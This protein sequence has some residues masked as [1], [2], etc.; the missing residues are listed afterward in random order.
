[1]LACLPHNSTQDMN[2]WR[3]SRE[4]R[5]EGPYAHG[6]R[7]LEVLQDRRRSNHLVRRGTA[8]GKEAN[9]WVTDLEDSIH[10]DIRHTA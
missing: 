8:G 9:A 7:L 5:D 4:C 1:M 3:A 6:Y 10:T 2:S